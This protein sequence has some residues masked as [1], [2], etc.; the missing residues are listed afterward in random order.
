MTA[1][2][3]FDFVTALRESLRGPPRRW[4][5]VFAGSAVTAIVIGIPT[6]MIANP[7]FTRMTATVWW[8]YPLWIIPSVLTGLLLATLIPASYA[9]S[10]AGG[11]SITTMASGGVLSA[12]AVGC[13]VCNKLV[14][15][16]I[17]VSGA[18]TLWAPLQ[19]ILGV[20]SILLLGVA[21]RRRLLATTA[22]E[23]R[24]AKEIPAVPLN[25]T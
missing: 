13:P 15:A 19:P 2:S 4:A 22:C 23:L 24:P 1:R 11:A 20:L 8:E 17:G 6:V 25:S 7:W 16:L 5:I 18:L 14:V 10:T 12:L 3:M 21:L 9:P